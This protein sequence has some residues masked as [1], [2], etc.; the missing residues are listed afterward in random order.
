LVSS[1]VEVVWG[2]AQPPALTHAPD[3][4]HMNHG[5]QEVVRNENR[6]AELRAVSQQTCYDNKTCNNLLSVI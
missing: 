5:N 3:H 4:W 2:K 1:S 6:S